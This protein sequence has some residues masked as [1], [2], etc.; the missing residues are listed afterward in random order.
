KLPRQFRPLQVEIG[1]A[2]QDKQC[3]IWPSQVTDDRNRSRAE[4]KCNSV[5]GQKKEVKKGKQKRSVV[6]PEPPGM[7]RKMRATQA[8]DERYHDRAQDSKAEASQ[9]QE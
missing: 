1:D 2:S 3:E 4:L 8:E 5:I 9:E 7:I 6:G